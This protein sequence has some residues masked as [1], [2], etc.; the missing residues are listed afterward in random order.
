MRIQTRRS[1]FTAQVFGLSAELLFSAEYRD[2]CAR[3]SHDTCL[4]PS[5]LLGYIQFAY[6]KL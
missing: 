3:S 6:L 1:T 2:K 5:I 4:F